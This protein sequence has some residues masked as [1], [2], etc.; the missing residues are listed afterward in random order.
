MEVILL[1]KVRNLGDLGDTVKV[2]PGYGRNF[3]MP[4]GIALPATKANLSVFEERRAELQAASQEREDRAKAR[5]EK[6]R[7]QE[8]VIAMRASDEGKLFGSVGPQEIS[9]KITEETVE[10]TPREVGLTEGTIRLVGYYTALLQLHAEVEVEVSIVV[11]QQTDMGVNMPSRVEANAAEQD[12]V[13]ATDVEGERVEEAGEPA[14]ETG[15]EA[16]PPIDE[17]ENG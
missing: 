5:A 14:D 6:L 9:D 13:A 2:R 17:R 1:Q 8:Y 7:G 4:R 12:D 10:V 15:T 11:A 3:L 16:D